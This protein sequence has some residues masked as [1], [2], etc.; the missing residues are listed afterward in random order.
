MSARRKGGNRLVPTILRS[1]KERTLYRLRLRQRNWDELSNITG[2]LRSGQC[3]FSYIRL[4]HKRLHPNHWFHRHCHQQYEFYMVESGK[5]TV[6]VGRMG[7]KLVKIGP[8]EAI[9]LAPEHAHSMEGT[10][11]TRVINGHF[12]LH[13]CATCERMLKQCS[14]KRML[15]SHFSLEGLR[16]LTRL[17]GRLG[18]AETGRALS[19][20]FYAILLYE[21]LGPRIGSSRK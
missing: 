10:A 4:E 5:T 3:M 20:I 16:L 21:F 19:D 13:T 7:D 6:T 18:R 17:P 11:P 15:L 9:I 14:G 12:S 1:Q 2:D 8:G